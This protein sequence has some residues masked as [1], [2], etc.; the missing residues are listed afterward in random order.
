MILKGRYNEIMDKISLTPEARARILD[1]IRA[2]DLGNRTGAASSRAPAWK[3]YLPVAAM[4]A[5]VLSGVIAWKWWTAPEVIPDGGDV[6][7]SPGTE[8]DPG[9]MT[10]VRE[11]DSA[12]ALEALMGYPVEEPAGL[13]FEPERTVYRAYWYGMAE[14]TVTG[15]GQSAK[16]RKQPGTEDISG[17]AGNEYPSSAE[18]E[19][20]GTAV[21]LRGIQSGGLYNIASWQRD[22]YAYALELSEPADEETMLDVIRATVPGMGE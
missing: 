4:A 11:A 20:G 19:L 3:R 2:M 22:G 5:L 21:S 6:P 9:D 13:P 16:L 10:T 8:T 1:N 17:T 18:A 12:E 14:V 15:G 7:L